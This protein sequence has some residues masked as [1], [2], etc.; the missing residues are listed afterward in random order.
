MLGL[1]RH[2]FGKDVAQAAA[3]SSVNPTALTV[4]H[5]AGVLF[6][7]DGWAVDEV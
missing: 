5:A 7:A 4:A 3:G 6:A 1:C 2:I